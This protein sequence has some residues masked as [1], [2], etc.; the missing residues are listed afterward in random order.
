MSSGAATLSI[1]SLSLGAHTVTAAYSGDGNFNT[2]NST[3]SPLTQTVNKANTT[4]AVTS[5]ANPSVSGQPVTFTAT[6]SATAPGTG[7][8]TGTV[9]F[10]DGATPIGTNT[11]SSGQATFTTSSLSVASHTISVV[12]NG[13]ASFDTSTSPN[14]TQTVNKDSTTTAVASSANP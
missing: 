12:Y 11:L 1:S 13:D 9:I 4:T 3:A 5:S 14:L 2:S 7:T 6:V 8:P 10:K